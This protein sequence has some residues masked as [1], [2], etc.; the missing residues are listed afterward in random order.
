MHYNKETGHLV[1]TKTLETDE[2][3]I[4]AGFAVLDSPYFNWK[5]LQQQKTC[6]IINLYFIQT[7]FQEKIDKSQFLDKDFILRNK[8][9]KASVNLKYNL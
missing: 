5:L 8:L 6:T 3:G 7:I 2:G 1:R 4:A 9:F